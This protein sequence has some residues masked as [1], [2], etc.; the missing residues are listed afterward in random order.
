MRMLSAADLDRCLDFPSLVAAL[1]RAHLGAA[2][3]SEDLLLQEPGGGAAHFLG[4][5][6]WAPDQALGIKLVTVFPENPRRP[7]PKPTVQGLYLLFDGADGSPL[8]ALEGA[9][10]T[11]WKTAAD[12][13]LGSE[14][15]S[16]TDARVLLMVGAGAMAAPLIRAHRA[17]RPSLQR[18]LLW[19]RTPAGAESLAR[20]LRAEG[21][22]AEPVSR[23]EAAVPEAGIVCCA[24][25]A[26]APL[27]LG[28][29]LSPGAHLDLVGGYRPDMREADDEAL[30]RA[31]IFVDSRA[32]TLRV[33][34]DLAQPLERG[35][36]AESDVLGDLYELCQ[37]AAGRLEARDI[38]LFKNGGGG[39]LDLMTARA[40]LA[41]LA[42]E[43]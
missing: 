35:V 36:I 22:A 5:L 39:H 34:G 9:S 14:L 17:V 16:R 38:T 6:A 15:L 19:N 21:I 33:C 10:L 42:A 31:R 20:R 2:P 23:L 25:A 1:R 4:R 29:W 32:S 24:T 18:V 11:A 7:D 28:R 8:A 40:A 13:A 3:A 12:S 30:G 41:A 27:V 43:S 37:G 26:T